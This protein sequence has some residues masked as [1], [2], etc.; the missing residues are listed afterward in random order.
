[1]KPAFSFVLVFLF[2]MA[3]HTQGQTQRRARVQAT[4]PEGY[5]QTPFIET[6]PEPEL[7]EAEKKRGYL[8]FHRPITEP[9]QANT[10]P[11][12]SERLVSGLS[13]FATPGEWEP[14]TLGVYPLRDLENF[15]VK[16]SNLTGPDGSTIDASRLT[17][18]L[19][20]YWNMGYPRYASRETYR[21]VPELM[22]RVDVH[23]SP[24][25][26]CQRWWI[27]IHVPD[28]AA[29][30]IY[31]GT[32]SVQDDGFAQAVE[33]PLSLRVLGFSLK[34]DP[35]KHYSAYYR[36]RD[37]ATY[38]DKDEAFYQQAS[39]N[40]FQAM[41]DYGIDQFPTLYLTADKDATKVSVQNEEE[42]DRLIAS[43][44]SG[45]IPILGG[46]AIARLYAATTP[47]G[48]RGSHWAIS[49]LPPPEFY[50]RLTQLFRDFETERIARGWPPMICCPL[51]EVAASHEAFGVKVFE[52][53]HRAGVRTFITK[54]PTATDARSYAPYVDVWCSQPYAIG[55]QQ[56][57]AQESHEYWSY[58][59]HIAGELKNRR[60]MCKGGRMTY[61]FGFWRSGYTTLI[62]W[63]WSW[64]MPPD[65]FDYLRSRQSGC[66]MRI[67]EAGEIIPP[68]YWEC[69]REGRDDAR[70][71]YTLQ[72][73][74][75]ERE[76]S[77][78]QQCLQQVAGA[79][80]LLQEN[81]D[82]IQV[83]QRYLSEDMWPSEEFNA[84]R[85]R[86]ATMI[87]TL[88]TYPAATQASAPSVLVDRAE[89]GDSIN[90]SADAV[91]EK[92][93][94]DGIVT[95]RDIG[96]DF[97]EWNN[98]TV[99]GEIEITPEASADQKPS[100]RWKVKVDYSTGNDAAYPVG[101]PRI[102]RLF[103]KD[104]LD[105]SGYDFLEF[106]IRVDSDRDEVADDIT[107][108]GLSIRNHGEP[109]KLYE[110]RVDLGDQQRVWL[111]LRFSI[112]QLIDTTALGATPWQNIQ[113]LQLFIAE[114]DYPDHTA[115]SFD[116]ASARLLAAS[117]PLIA[118]VEAARFL[119][120]PATT[121]PISFEVIGLS[122]VK[123]GSHLVSASLLDQNGE[124]R[125]TRQQDLIAGGRLDLDTDRLSPGK[126]RLQTRITSAAGELGSESSRI[127]EAL[128]GP[129]F[130]E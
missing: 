78:D 116:I 11:L 99:E 112:K 62:P 100:M 84:R 108:F 47:G 96:G 117:Q 65:P 30:G 22:E 76:A 91:L 36:T 53:V 40:E 97:S 33:I 19:Q 31:R 55:Y 110:T 73:A 69:F 28:D 114:S 44:M 119:L 58:P 80:A 13:A 41:R 95:C 42:I 115:L 64:T 18:R 93:I 77:T 25:R 63:H 1:M 3:V 46:N 32:V 111:P 86:L 5:R 16:I 56:I 79:K 43:G 45:R 60:V 15:R 120:L 128:A 52:A 88:L 85:W 94:A 24:A 66:G 127:V 87:E 51:D 101:W 54:S 68:I 129:F 104:D 82:A 38:Q 74:V 17:V 121:I 113:T 26:E 9:V 103:K 29:A 34:R 14:V 37:R 105:L 83:Q 39:A 70:Y 23:S 27:Q 125:A 75:F 67:D 102:R 126:Y 12:S 90:P 72:Q 6:A 35:A 109:G 130:D 123:K 8:L 59:N 118:K 50:T 61:G 81:W 10:H 122:T 48:E 57:I 89:P 98:D 106:M 4:I 7:T 21:R 71:L 124:V 20:T 49:K 2:G 92:A 107:P